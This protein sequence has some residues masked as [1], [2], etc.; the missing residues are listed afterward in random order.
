MSTVSLFYY[1]RVIR[2]MYVIKT[3]GRLIDPQAPDDVVERWRL[4]PT[5][6]IATAVLFLGMF[7]VG[8]YVA[9]LAV[10]ADGAAKALFG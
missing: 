8:L 6:Y 5:G 4:T 2:A 7:A 9:P 10:A 3:D 1:L